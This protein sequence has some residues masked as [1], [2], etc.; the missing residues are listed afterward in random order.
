MTGLAILSILWVGGFFAY[1]HFTTER[2]RENY[3]LVAW[4]VLLAPVFVVLFMGLMR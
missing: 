3:L 2:Q 1:F 4:L